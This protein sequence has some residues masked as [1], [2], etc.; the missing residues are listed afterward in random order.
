MAAD[1]VRKIVGRLSDGIEVIA[2]DQSA[3]QRR[4]QQ[5][6]DE[7]DDKFDLRVFH[8]VSGIPGVFRQTVS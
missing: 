2:G 5:H 1:G 3:G 6:E 8:G 4:T 7:T